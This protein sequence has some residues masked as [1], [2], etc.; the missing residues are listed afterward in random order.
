MSD[1][2]EPSKLLD[3]GTADDYATFFYDTLNPLTHLDRY[4]RDVA[5]SFECAADD[6]HVPPRG[7]LQFRAA[8]RQRKAAAKVRVQL[9]RNRTHRQ[10]RDPIFWSESLTWF[11]QHSD[12]RITAP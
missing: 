2:Y 3:P 11:E 5:I 8:L 10:L 1:L 4:D 12:L 7:A 9:H 6:T